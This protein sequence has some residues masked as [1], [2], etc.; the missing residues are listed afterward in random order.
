MKH[1]IEKRI[2]DLNLAMQLEREKISRLE[3]RYRMAKNIKQ[4]YLRK[5]DYY[6]E[7]DRLRENV[8]K[9]Y[10]ELRTLS[11]RAGWWWRYNNPDKR[12]DYWD[13]YLIEIGVMGEFII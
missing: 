7:R 13:N 4:R 10:V 6:P 5:A 8:I 3:H 1:R 12:A 9:I 11:K 2:E